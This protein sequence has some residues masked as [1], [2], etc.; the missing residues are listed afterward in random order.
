LAGK[1]KST[2]SRTIAHRY[3]GLHRLGASFFFSR[4]GGDVGN[5]GKFVTSIAVQLASNV[6]PFKRHVC[7][8]IEERPNI[9][10]QPLR[11]QWHQLVLRPLSKLDDSN[12]HESY[13][14]V[15]DALDECDD[16]N[17]IRIILQLLAEARSLK[18]V[19]L[20]VLLTSRPE[21]PIQYGFYQIPDTEHQNFVLHDTS[22][23]NIDHDISIF[24][25]YKLRPIGQEYAL[26]TGWPEE[27]AI[28]CL[29]QHARGLFIWAATVSRFI[30][31]GK[32]LVARRLT[33]EKHLNEIYTTV[34]KHCIHSDYTDEKRE[35]QYRMLRRILGSIVVF[36]SPL[37]AGSLSRLLRITKRDIDETLNDLHAILNIPQQTNPI[38]LHHPSFRDFLLEKG[39]CEDSNFLVDEKQVHQKLV[40]SCIRLMSTSLKQDICGLDSSS[41]PAADIDS[42]RVE[43]SLPPEVQYACLYWIQHLQKSGIQLHDEDQVHQFLQ[44][45]LLHWLE[46]LG[47]MGK[48]SEGI[49]A[50]TSLESIAAVSKPLAQHVY[51]INIFF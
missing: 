9:S 24:L 3:F 40:A 33:P 37:S 16:E 4:G 48:V 21:I 18:M 14:L 51:F 36:F 15:V 8:A 29:V 7:E 45:H 35:D 38:R 19:R 46:A 30:S 11:D 31:E 6:P 2:I 26:E 22:P 28:R 25:K 27:E 10:S 50:I 42:D 32:Q 47:W 12:S 41:V 5:A 1:G 43:R 23:S 34:L 49:Y 13:I 39:R 17:D 44:E 20:Q